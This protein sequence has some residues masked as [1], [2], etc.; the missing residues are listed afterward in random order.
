MPLT[1]LCL[2]CGT[3]CASGRCNTCRNQRYG[4]EHQA[5]RAT[6]TPLVNQG[7]VD[8][9]WCHDPIEPGSRWDLGHN[10]HGP[11]TP[12]HAHC[13]RSAAARGVA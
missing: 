2:D 1:R 13:N 11:S 6:W 7:H 8:C 3:P 10:A 9:G 4:T 12:W 5:E